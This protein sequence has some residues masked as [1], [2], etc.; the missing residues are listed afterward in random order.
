[1]LLKPLRN[2]FEVGLAIT[3]RT[4]KNNFAKLGENLCETLRNNFEVGVAI[5]Q[6][7][8]KNN[9]KEFH[10]EQFSGQM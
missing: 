5:T 4:A 7:N 1:M 6:R 2:N 10:L 3:Q 8:A 9:L